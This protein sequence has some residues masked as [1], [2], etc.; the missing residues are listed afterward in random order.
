MSQLRVG[1]LMYLDQRISS[2]EYLD[3]VIRHLLASYPLHEM[4]PQGLTALLLLIYFKRDIT[5]EDLCEHVG[6]VFRRLSDYYNYLVTFSDL[7]TLQVELSNLITNKKLTQE[8]ICAACLGLKKISG[9]KVSSKYL[10]MSLYKALHNFVA[11][12]DPMDDF[13]LVT[14]MTTLS[15]GN[16]IFF[17]DIDQVSSMLERMTNQLPLLKMDT[18][19]KLLTFPLTLGFSVK[20]IEDFVFS[21]L[22]QKLEPLEPWNLTQICSYMSR[23]P[24]SENRFPVAD[25]VRFLEDKLEKISELDEL[26]DIIECFHFLAQMKV[27]SPKFNK[28]IF[29]EI[30]ALPKELFDNKPDMTIIADKVSKAV[31]S[32]LNLHESQERA[33]QL[34]RNP[35]KTTSI[36]T[37]LPAFIS[38]CYS[39]EVEVREAGAELEAGRAHAISRSHH[40][41]LPKQVLVPMLP[42]KVRET[43]KRYLKIILTSFTGTADKVQAADQLPPC[44]DPLHGE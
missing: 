20:Q 25:L 40:T 5:L 14:V 10:R 1:F 27:F 8:E 17:D 38:T 42:S 23:T 32:K 31:S 21:D 19:V 36:L 35:V 43:N 24:E 16:M 2:G 28:L 13:F 3:K 4:G 15:R 34:N 22:G 18:V 37:R 12:G 44:S 39:L 7:E 11:R 33:K 6:I 9:F 41:P 29:S 30:N 26:M